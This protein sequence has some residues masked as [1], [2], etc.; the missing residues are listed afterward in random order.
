MN[1]LRIARIVGVRRYTS[2]RLAF[3][4]PCLSASRC[5]PRMKPA[6]QREAVQGM[7]LRSFAFRSTRWQVTEIL[8]IHPQQIES[9]EVGLASSAQGIVPRS[10]SMRAEATYVPRSSS[11]TSQADESR[12]R[13]GPNE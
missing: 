5:Q 6:G 7:S 2:G 1:S 9:V 13:L 11:F 8:T 12:R 10:R 4:G 3:G